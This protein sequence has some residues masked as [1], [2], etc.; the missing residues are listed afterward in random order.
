MGQTLS[1]SEVKKLIEEDLSFHVAYYYSWSLCFADE[2]IQELNLPVN[3]AVCLVNVLNM[4]NG[5]IKKL[6]IVIERM[7]HMWRHRRVNRQIEHLSTLL[8]ERLSHIQ[9][10]FLYSLQYRYVETF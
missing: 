6:K 3:S 10:L 5:E 4:H 8:C 1:V 9:L 7:F 2:H